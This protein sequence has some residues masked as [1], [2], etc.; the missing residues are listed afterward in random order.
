[1]SDRDVS[2][3]CRVFLSTVGHTG[4]LLLSYDTKGASEHVA[5]VFAGA[6]QQMGV[7][8]IWCGRIPAPALAFAA[9]R[10]RTPAVLISTRGLSRSQLALRFFTPSGEISRYDESRMS[11]SFR[12]TRKMSVDP[13]GLGDADS[14]PL[15]EYIIRHTVFQS[16][17]P[18]K[19]W[20][21]GIIRNGSTAE[22]A[23][24]KSLMLLGAHV[25][26]DV[27]L[28]PI[29]LVNTRTPDDVTLARL[30][31][32]RSDERLDAIAGTNASGE[33]PIVMDDVG[34]LVAGDVMAPVCAAELGA[35]RVIAAATA[36]GLAEAMAPFER[37]DRVDP[38]HK[39]ILEAVQKANQRGGQSVV[40][41][42]TR[43]GVIL[44][45]DSLHGKQPLTRVLCRDGVLP[46]VTFLARAARTNMR[47]SDYLASLNVPHRMSRRIPDLPWPV[48]ARLLRSI[49]ENPPDLSD[50]PT[51]PVTRMRT[52]AG[53]RLEF[54]S[55]GVLHF[56]LCAATPELLIH[57]EAGTAAEAR[58]LVE[59]GHSRTV[60]GQ[61]TKDR[62]A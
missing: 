10:R 55:G 13:A 16:G 58:N 59:I 22:Q 27:E 51:G 61:S 24:T 50:G 15:T 56:E 43:G 23:L 48:S 3:Y 38:N 29:I 45:F 30:R 37:V 25:T 11:A 21:I 36:S 42:D 39:G 40:G 49:L 5:R 14:Q 18:L 62:T 6:A 9:A 57:A 2:A 33:H 4:A 7:H 8:P 35:R 60:R 54:A 12:T 17:W 19:G 52:V 41:Y 53:L 32:W 31:K 34:H 20:R 46:I 47:P 44:G 1:M 28:D 26:V